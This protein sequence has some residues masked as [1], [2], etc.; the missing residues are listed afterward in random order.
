MSHRAVT[1][2]HSY[3]PKFNTPLPLSYQKQ[4]E[5]IRDQLENYTQRNFQL[6]GCPL[7]KFTLADVNQIVK[8]RVY[9]NV[10]VDLYID[11]HKPFRLRE[12]EGEHSVCDL[13]N[14]EAI[15]EITY[16]PCV[17]GKTPVAIVSPGKV[18]LD[19]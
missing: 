4:C 6:N 3:F 19:V 12:K 15:I 5:T 16:A 13:F 8:I 18:F 14:R 1:F 9:E 7:E 11:T 17:D 2:R 10:S